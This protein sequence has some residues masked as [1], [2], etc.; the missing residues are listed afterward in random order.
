MAKEIADIKEFLELIRRQD[1]NSATVKIN[2]KLNK[3]GKAFRQTK[4]KLRG[5][6]YLYT[7][8]VNDAGKAK[9]LLQSLPPTFNVN[10]L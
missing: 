7:L 5:S 10:K 9:K 8:I 1:V 3:N 4:F 6:R 2:K